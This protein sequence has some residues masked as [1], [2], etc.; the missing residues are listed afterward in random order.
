[1]H[2]AF[3]GISP[4]MM[5]EFLRMRNASTPLRLPPQNT[6]FFFLAPKHTTPSNHERQ[7]SKLGYTTRTLTRKK[8]TKIKWL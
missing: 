6:V 8:K 2:Q 5:N 4:K 3:H 1:M 7:S